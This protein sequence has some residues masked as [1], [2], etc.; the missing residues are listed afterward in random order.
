MRHERARRAGYHC[1]GLRGGTAAVAGVAGRGALARWCVVTRRGCAASRRDLATRSRA[2]AILGERRVRRAGQAGRDVD[3]AVG[4]SPS[5]RYPR[6]SSRAR[7]LD[8]GDRPR[9][10]ARR[11]PRPA[12]ARTA[13][14]LDAADEP[15]ARRDQLLVGGDHAAVELDQPQRVVQPVHEVIGVAAVDAGAAAA[16]EREGLD[17]RARAVGAR[18]W[19]AEAGERPDGSA[20]RNLYASVVLCLR[21][22]PAAERAQGERSTSGSSDSPAR[23]QRRRRRRQRAHRL[24]RLA[25]LVVV[26]H[27]RPRSRVL[28]EPAAIGLV[29]A[30]VVGASP[31]RR[32]PCR[33]GGAAGRSSRRPPVEGRTPASIA[34]RSLGCTAVFTHS[35]P[36]VKLEACRT[37][38]RALQQHALVR[39]GDAED[40]TSRRR[41]GPGCRA[42]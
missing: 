34:S 6:A 36:P 27:A 23:H 19:P 7:A 13:T 41:R 39:L 24:D 22:E 16:A 37:F 30:A 1:V 11:T 10:R 3:G 26:G 21:A 17:P 15:A 29:E 4:R 20:R 40:A 28:L 31:A 32:S 8:L 25:H 14:S 18:R 38:E 12:G 9:G 35:R 5:T 33:S 2:I 42:A